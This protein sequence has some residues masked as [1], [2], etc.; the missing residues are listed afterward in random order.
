MSD[1]KI[2]VLHMGL[3]DRRG[4]IESFL[5]NMA[6]NADWVRFQF[7]FLCYGD[8]PAFGDELRGM[9]AELVRMP[10]RKNVTAYWL[11]LKKT[12]AGYDVLHLH[13]NSPGDF[14]PVL[15]ARGT[16]VKVVVHAHN[17]AANLTV[18]ELVARMGRRAFARHADLRL[19]CSGPAGEYVFGKGSDFGF[20]P[21]SIDL[22]AYAFDPVAREE[23]R[24]C[25][26]VVAD[27]F[28]VGIVGRLAPQK[29][30]PFMVR[31]FASFA[32]NHPGSV[33]VS[34]G[35]GPLHEEVA[36]LA[37]SLGVA[38]AVRLLG[39]RDDVARLY[40]AFDCACCPSL[41]E[42][43]SFFILEAQASGLPCLASAA[44]PP[45]ARATGLVRLLNLDEVAWADA[46]EEIAASGAPRSGLFFED[47]EAMRSFDV[48]E[49]GRRL[50][51]EY[52]GL[53]AS[54]M[55]VG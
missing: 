48:D 7:D 26:G 14:L 23:Q 2:R 11:F 33:L 42:G 49:A 54:R 27:A 40:S 29:N 4:G 24:R 44:V 43:F 45:E 22:A 17:T 8:N 36:A 32:K 28:V 30:Y 53:M 41:Y 19:A 34:V 52:D 50:M 51:S 6:C 55:E 13:K 21:N 10:S 46:L 15:A 47:A 16:G 18:P 1:R 31:A 35:E 12:I 37:E 25:L 3:D 38:D 9:G 20:F 39:R 5:Y